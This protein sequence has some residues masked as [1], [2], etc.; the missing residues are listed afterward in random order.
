MRHHPTASLGNS[1]STFWVGLFLV[2]VVASGVSRGLDLDA[3]WSEDQ[4]KRTGLNDYLYAVG[5]FV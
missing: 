4:Y 3:R 2:L 5:E 1:L